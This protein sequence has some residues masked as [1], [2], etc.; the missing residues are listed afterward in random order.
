MTPLDQAALDEKS[1]AA[2]PWWLQ[3]VLRLGVLSALV[4]VLVWFLMSVVVAGQRDTK[5]AIKQ[6]QDVVTAIRV[7]QGRQ[8]QLLH[9]MCRYQ[10]KTERERSQCDAVI[11]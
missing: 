6:T 7:D 2:A 3:A 9:L 5:D 1:I 4:L 10:A 8:L 11:R